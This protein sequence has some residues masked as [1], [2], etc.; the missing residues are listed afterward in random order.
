METVPYIKPEEL[1]SVLSIRAQD[2][3][4]RLLGPWLL[5]QI[6]DE[7]D[8]GSSQRCIFEWVPCLPGWADVAN[9]FPIRGGSCL[10]DAIQIRSVQPPRFLK[11]LPISN[12]PYANEFESLAHDFEA[13][14]KKFP[15]ILCVV[16]KK[17][18]ER[19][20]LFIIATLVDA[21]K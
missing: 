19:I 11:E 16:S 13:N 17:L 14:I 2:E 21:T 7:F 1:R 20:L 3:K 15:C 10:L 8:E 18:V 4:Y 9:A 5:F 6:A 12:A